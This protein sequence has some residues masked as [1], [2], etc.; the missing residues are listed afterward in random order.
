G[1]RLAVEQGDLR[2][3]HYVRAR[4]TLYGL[5]EE[6]QLDVAQERQAQRNTAEAGDRIV[7]AKVGHRRSVGGGSDRDVQVRRQ[8]SGRLQ[9]DDGV[10]GCKDVGE[11]V[12]RERTGGDLR[13]DPGVLGQDIHVEVDADVFEEVVFD[14]DEADLDGDFL[15]LQPPQ[16]LQEVKH[17]L[18]DI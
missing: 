12:R 18:L 8:R 11:A 14:G 5:H 13:L 7:T 15:I 10:L 9:A 16:R 4:V 1:R 3:L 6:E 17:L 2:G